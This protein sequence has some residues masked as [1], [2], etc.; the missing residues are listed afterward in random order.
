MRKSGPILISVIIKHEPVA[1]GKNEY[2]YRCLEFP[3]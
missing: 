1:I 3:L 2:G